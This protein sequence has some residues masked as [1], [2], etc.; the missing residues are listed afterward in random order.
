LTGNQHLIKQYQDL[1]AS[2]TYGNTSVKTLR[3]IRPEISILRPAS[4]VD[5][6]C[7]RS[8]LVDFLG[9][10]YT[11]ERVRY[12]PAIPEYSELPAK[13][14]ELLVSIDVLEHIE[15][16]DLDD[17]LSEMRKIC[18]NALLIVDLK[19]AELTLPDGRNAHVTLHSAEW[20]SD[21]LSQHFG[22]LYRIKTPR[23]SRAGFRT[24]K[25][26]LGQ[27]WRYFGL[28]LKENLAYYFLR[29]LG[30]KRY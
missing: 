12:D 10:S 18:R 20:W 19:P 3:F 7:G 14:A 21:K 4:I 17:V 16:Q 24:W 13:Q 9:G 29:I 22:T 15:E 30:I 5:Y 23:S 6:G 1:H 27:T 28:R 26:G 25:R 8:A 2:R 11:L